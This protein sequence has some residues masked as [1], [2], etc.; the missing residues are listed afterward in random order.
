M[1]SF[2]GFAILAGF[3]SQ[4]FT[5]RLKSAASIMFGLNLDEHQQAPT[6]APVQPSQ[7]TPGA[8]DAPV[9]PAT[10]MA[11]PPSG[12]GQVVPPVVSQPVPPPPA[13]RTKMIN[14]D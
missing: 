4:E 10:E 12:G 7:P 5:E 3:A 1:I 9:V 14:R 11:V 13:P 8:P 6:P 2:L